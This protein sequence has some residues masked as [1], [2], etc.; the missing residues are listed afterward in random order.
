MSTRTAVITGASRGIGRAISVELARR[1]WHVVAT[2]RNVADLND[3]DVAARVRLDVTDDESV[4]AAAEQIGAVDAVV[5]NAGVG[6]LGPIE[7]T[8]IDTI[9]ELFDVNVLGPIRVVQAFGKALRDSSGTIVNVSS[10]LGRA[11]PPLIGPYSASKWALEGLSEAMRHEFGHHGVRVVAVQPGIVATDAMALFVATPEMD[12]PEGAYAALL[13]HSGSRPP[14]AV[15]EPDEVAIAV[16]DALDAAHV[17]PRLPI[18]AMAEGIAQLRTGT[19]DDEAFDAVVRE[20]FAPA[21][22]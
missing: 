12:T 9:S 22:W 4:R 21:G 16:A 7:T 19:P 2:A 13:A 3:L 15:L 5:N 8:S 20:M 11:A 10:L 18:G 14:A 6:L 17:P 1:D